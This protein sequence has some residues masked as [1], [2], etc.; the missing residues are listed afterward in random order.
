MEIQH[1][2][3]EEDEE[4]ED[5]EERDLFETRVRVDSGSAH[6]LTF[7]DME[8]SMN[9]FSGDDNVNVQ[10]WLSEFE[11]MC[12]L[13]DW[14]DVQRVIYVKKLLRDSAKLFVDYERCR[15]S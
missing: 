9:T 4:E 5:E 1:R 6:I 2:E 7:R 15:K 8:E 12:D 11:E 13:C 10:S 14:T 3:D